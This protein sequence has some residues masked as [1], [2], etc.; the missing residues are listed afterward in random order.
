MFDEMTYE[1]I[2]EDMVEEL[3]G[4]LDT[5]EGSLLY[6][7]I[8]KCALQ[9]SECYSQLSYLY[10]QLFVDTMEFDNLITFASDRGIEY[11][12]ATCAIVVMQC[13]KELE[14]GTEFLCGEYSYTISKEQFK[15]EGIYSYLAVCNLA[16]TEANN[17]VGEITALD[18]L[19]E[20]EGEI[21][22]IFSEGED[23]EKEDDFRERV[24]MNIRTQ[25]FGGNRSDYV[26][27]LT[28]YA[29]VKY[30]KIVRNAGDGYI[31]A[32]LADENYSLVPEDKIKMIQEDMC[33]GAYEGDGVVPF[34]HKLI[35][36]SVKEAEF[37]LE[38][39]YEGIE[40][41]GDL[42]LENI[43]KEA[44]SEYES[45]IKED[46]ENDKIFVSLRKIAAKL[47]LIDEIID[48]DAQLIEAPDCA[49]QNENGDYNIPIAY[50]PKLTAEFIRQ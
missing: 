4:G 2:I 33:P 35:V 12:D 41:A 16:G 10:D 24:K 28:N 38:V 31:Y 23:E 25:A 29:G 13:D 34:G 32:Y 5:S 42:E 15:T 19:G 30:C 44:L 6:H 17:N 48:I 49:I 27:K 9:L 21:I 22:E 40:E 7:A 46:W 37:Q 36:N 3:P 26:N 1:K 18:Y 45:K 47:T 20:T 11:K 14:I 50:I 39:V 43:L 8:C